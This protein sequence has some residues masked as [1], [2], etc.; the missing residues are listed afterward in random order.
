MTT[1]NQNTTNGKPITKHYVNIANKMRGFLQHDNHYFDRTCPSCGGLFSSYEVRNCKRCGQPL[2]FITLADGRPMGI[3]EGTF[4]PLLSNKD[5][6]SL[7]KGLLSRKGAIPIKYRFKMFSFA[8]GNGVLAPHPQHMNMKE[9]AM[10]ELLMINH[11]VEA[12]YFLS[13]NSVLTEAMLDQAKELLKNK[14]T[15]GAIEAVLKGLIINVELMFKLYENRGDTIKVVMEPKKKAEATISY[16][17]DAQ[18]NPLPVTPPV[19]S[20]E[21]VDVMTKKIAELQAQMLALTGGQ[22]APAPAPAPAPKPAPTAAQQAAG[23]AMADKYFTDDGGIYDSEPSDADYQDAGDV[24][25]F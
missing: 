10:I 8:D 9:G 18:G 1:Q 4:R 15:K 6:E 20:Q 3:S 19:L 14:N 5:K 23:D 24:E 21:T 17:V 22:A 25:P 2:T 13:N 7:E 16:K 11:P 12:T